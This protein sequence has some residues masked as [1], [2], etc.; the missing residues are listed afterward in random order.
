M[1]W[2]KNESCNI[3]AECFLVPCAHFL[4]SQTGDKHL[5]QL[6]QGSEILNF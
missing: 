6:K 4:T 1:Q 3:H 2:Q 5:Q